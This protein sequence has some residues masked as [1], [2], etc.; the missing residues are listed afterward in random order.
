VLDSIYQNGCN[1]L[2][3]KYVGDSL[4]NSAVYLSYY[5][6]LCSNALFSFPRWTG[7]SSA[8]LLQRT[9]P[10]LATTSTT[11]Y[12]TAILPPHPPYTPL[13]VICSHSTKVLSTSPL[14]FQTQ[15]TVNHLLNSGCVRPGL[16]RPARR[17]R[18]GRRL[19]HRMDRHQ[20][21]RRRGDS[22][23]NYCPKRTRLEPVGA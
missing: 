12:A 19:S 6:S 15:V 9:L 3:F 11:Y 18:R 4:P 2:R 1:G 8:V 7:T 10:L 13:P 16:A 17:V 23:V 14:I 22:A 21:L 5:L 20:L